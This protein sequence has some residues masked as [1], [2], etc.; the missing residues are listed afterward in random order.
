[1]TILEYVDYHASRW[2][3]EP[4]QRRIKELHQLQGIAQILKWTEEFKAQGKVWK[5][6]KWVKL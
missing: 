5:D 2:T 6:G 4:S 1:M 3:A